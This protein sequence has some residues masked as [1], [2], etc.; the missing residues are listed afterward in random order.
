M[1]HFFKKICISIIFLVLAIF[2]L[3]FGW[4]SHIVETENY[5]YSEA[6]QDRLRNFADGRYDYGVKAWFANDADAAEKFFMDAVNADVLHIDSWLKLAQVKL[7]KNDAEAAGRI[8]KF[9]DDLTNDVVKWKWQQIVL[10]GQL[11]YDEMFVKDI[12]FVLPYYQLRNDALQL[13]DMHVG[14]NA[15]KMAGVLDDGNLAHYLLWLMKWRRTEESLYVYQQMVEKTTVDDDLQERFINYLVS[16][17]ELAY[18]SKMWKEYAGIDGIMNPG[19]EKPISRVAFDWR[20][21]NDPDWDMWRVDSETVEGYYAL[22]ISFSGKN[23][24]NFHH[25]SQIVPVSSGK[26]YRL[27]YEWQS[28]NITTDQRPF[29]EIYGYD[30]KG[31]YEKSEMIPANTDWRQ[32]AITFLTPEDCRAVVVR[33]R[34]KE[35]HRFDSK[36]AGRLWLDNFS[37]KEC[38]SING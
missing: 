7:E 23:N 22:E 1:P 10:A 16:Q 28:R 27:T 26:T 19:F 25:L 29:V 13:L 33:L 20:Q 37:I 35:S 24:I 17:K 11:G 6:E 15:E 14:M 8:L 5:D 2:M 32:D 34:R 21:G 18:A 36:I 38:P 9:T 12:N 31:L 3:R 30:C 4:L